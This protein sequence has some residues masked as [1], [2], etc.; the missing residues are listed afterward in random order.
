MVN[1]KVLNIKHDIYPFDIEESVYIIKNTYSSF[2]RESVYL[3]GVDTDIR[4]HK[5][6]IAVLVDG[7]HF[8]CNGNGFL[9]LICS[10]Y[11]VKKVIALEI[12]QDKATEDASVKMIFDKAAYHPLK[13]SK[14]EVIGRSI[15]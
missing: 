11:Q 3:I 14:L 13:D 6:Y 15:D 8:I 10:E 2:L 7:Y 4:L 5:R 9:V 1:V 12:H